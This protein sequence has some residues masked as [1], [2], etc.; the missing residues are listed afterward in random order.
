MKILVIASAGG[1][2]IELLRLRPAFE[3]HEVTYVST[4]ESFREM[5]SGQPY[6]CVPD[7]S[8]WD[9]LS[10][11]KCL[12]AVHKIVKSVRPDVVLTT[13]AAPGLM[14]LISGRTLG[15]KTIWI[16]S[17]AQVEELSLSG[18]IAQKFA[19]KTY[20]QWPDLASEK[21]QFSG[22]VL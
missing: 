20:T 22:S 13:G 21:V 18:K 6:F 9:K 15:A 8:R 17:I 16:D 3:N 10:L 4:K 5:V 11:L 2:W 12:W 14:A 7:S 19:D 1:H